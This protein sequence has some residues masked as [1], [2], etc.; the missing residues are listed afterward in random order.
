M[1]RVVA[2]I[3]VAAFVAGAAEAK[4]AQ[5][6]LR[7][8]SRGGLVASWQ[9][10]MNLW[11][12]ASGYPADK[13]LRARFGGG[14]TID[15]VFGAN[16]LAATKRFQQEGH[17]RATGTV[18]LSDWLAWIGAEV[19]PT[20]GAVGIRSGDFGGFTGWWQVSLNRW[21]QRHQHPEIV[22]DCSFGLQTVAATR[23]FQR[24]MY[25]QT[26]GVVDQKT[27]AE[28]MRLGLTHLP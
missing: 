21:L 16:T 15:G 8:G 10:A 27:W 28:A 18:G 26:S 3:V 24:A 19:T 20:G 5:P 2:C 17:Q 7:L 25:L 12:S 6:L 23:T 1:R 4:A 13:R 9:R 14:L 22:V 11:L